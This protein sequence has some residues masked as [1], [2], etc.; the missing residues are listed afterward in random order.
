[1][2]DADPESSVDLPT[3]EPVLIV[4]DDRIDA[5]TPDEVQRHRHWEMLVVS[6][7]V[8]AL[9]LALRL[10]DGGSVEAPIGD[11]WQMPPLCMSRA[12][13]GIECPGCGL[14]RS[15]VSLAQGQVT[16]SLRFH[17]LGW[18]MAFAVVIQVPYRLYELNR[19]AWPTPEH[20][21]SR[22]GSMLL[23]ALLAS[24]VLNTFGY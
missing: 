19:P 13:F 3:D 7:V 9:S 22:F 2:A 21:K 20:W 14:T 17:R 1:M 10:N 15:F 23:F 18:L 4:V 8:M 12:W 11:G 6:L 24:W 5:S 16:E